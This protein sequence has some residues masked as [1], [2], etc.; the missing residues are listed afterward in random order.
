MDPSAPTTYS[1]GF[2][3]Q[4]HHLVFLRLTS[5][6]VRP[7]SR[8]ALHLMGAEGSHLPNCQTNLV[9]PLHALSVLVAYYT[10]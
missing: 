6:S 3:S 7:L 1:P 4:A 2:E 10:V 8:G 9:I 5:G